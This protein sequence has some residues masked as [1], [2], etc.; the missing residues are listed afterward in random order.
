MPNS[1]VLSYSE[2]DK[3]RDTFNAAWKCWYDPRSWL[4]PRVGTGL[5]HA[6]N[7]GWQVVVLLEKEAYRKPVFKVARKAIP[8]VPVQVRVVGVIYAADTQ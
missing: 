8:N 3:A 6:G 7:G 1:S 2:A 4:R 5:G